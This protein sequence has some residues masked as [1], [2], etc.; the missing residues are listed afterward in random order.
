MIA[1]QGLGV[2]GG[3]VVGGLLATVSELI[4]QIIEE[5]QL[6]LE[7]VRINLIEN[8][9]NRL[10]ATIISS[11]VTK[12]EMKKTVNLYQP[13]LDQLTVDITGLEQRVSYIRR[14][15]CSGER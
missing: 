14:K 15:G 7:E 9:I 10:Q 1:T 3:M 2:R 12:Q 5:L 13:I 4:D 6:P 11:T 8:L